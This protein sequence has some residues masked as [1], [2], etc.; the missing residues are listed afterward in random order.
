MHAQRLRALHRAVTD[1]PTEPLAGLAR[2]TP[3]GIG[4]WGGPSRPGSTRCGR[5][6]S[7][8]AST[9]PPSVAPCGAWKSGV[10]PRA[11]DRPGRGVR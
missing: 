11:A 7:T 9:T 5:S 3:T 6:P 10:V 1:S 4:P 8:S 2:A